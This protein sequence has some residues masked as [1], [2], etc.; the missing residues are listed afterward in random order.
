[1]GAYKKSVCEMAQKQQLV[2]GRAYFEQ[3]TV[4]KAIDQWS[5]RF[6][7]FVKTKGQHFKQLLF[8][9]SRIV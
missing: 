9:I 2:E 8:M 3:T 4:K 5:R 6:G 7:A 1:M